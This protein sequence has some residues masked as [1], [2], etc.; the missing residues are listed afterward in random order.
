MS[1]RRTTGARIYKWRRKKEIFSSVGKKRLLFFLPRPSSRF[2][3]CLSLSLILLA[4]LSFLLSSSPSL[5]LLSKMKHNESSSYLRRKR[6]KKSPFPLFGKKRLSRSLARSSL[7]RSSSSKNLKTRTIRVLQHAAV[8]V[9]QHRGAARCRG[10]RRERSLGEVR[11]ALPRESRRE[12]GRP[13]GRGGGDGGDGEEEDDE[14]LAR[15]RGQDR[16]ATRH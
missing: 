14:L 4:S 5:H 6:R 16:R 7:A 10:H 11:R 9:F 3:L 12:Q 13:A 8:H 15:L 1:K 2:S